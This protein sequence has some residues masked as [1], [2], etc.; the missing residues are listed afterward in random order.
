MDAIQQAHQERLHAHQAQV[1]A[2]SQPHQLRL[3]EAADRDAAERD[4]APVRL[5]VLYT[6]ERRANDDERHRQTIV[7]IVCAYL[8][9]PYA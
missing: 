1:D 6:L 5:T 8:R 4:K 3:A 9:M 7:N 2:A